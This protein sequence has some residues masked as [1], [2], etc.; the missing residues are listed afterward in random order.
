MSR[1][2]K[3]ELLRHRLVQHEILRL[4]GYSITI[5]PCGGVTVDRRGHVRGVWHHDGES[6]GWTPA[7]YSEATHRSGDVDGAVRH[8]LVIL[9]AM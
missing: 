2:E 3:L 9:A 7:G 1:A 4:R 5:G 8:T 6:Y